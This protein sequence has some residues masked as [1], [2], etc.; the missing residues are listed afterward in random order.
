MAV[1][2]QGVTDEAELVFHGW[3]FAIEHAIG[4]AQRDMCVVAPLLTPSVRTC[5]SRD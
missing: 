3:P 1:L 5:L 2:H 4:V